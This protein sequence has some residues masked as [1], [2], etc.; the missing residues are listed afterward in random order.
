M[1]CQINILQFMAMVIPVFIPS[2]LALIYSC[3]VRFFDKYLWASS[4]LLSWCFSCRQAAWPCVFLNLMYRKTFFWQVLEFRVIAL[5]MALR[6]KSW[7]RILWNCLSFQVAAFRNLYLIR[8]ETLGS[9]GQRGGKW[10][11]WSP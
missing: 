7:N 6:V 9:G 3:S 5:T 10:W 11:M 1:F 4:L 8:S 2:C